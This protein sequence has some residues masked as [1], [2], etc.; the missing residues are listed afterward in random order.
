MAVQR[1]PVPALRPEQRRR[2]HR[3]PADRRELGPAPEFASGFDAV[4]HGVGQY[5]GIVWFFKGGQYVRYNLNHDVTEFGPVDIA[6]KWNDWP[7]AFADG[8]DF[9]FYGTGLHENHIY[10]F[11]GDQYI[12]YDLDSDRV[13]TVR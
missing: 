10:F 2:D 4:I 9:A 3:R 12:R 6:A 5:L 11:R 7:A 8:V 13:V 1:R